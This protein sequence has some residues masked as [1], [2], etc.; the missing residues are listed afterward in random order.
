MTI[1]KVI[2][3]HDHG[4]ENHPIQKRL[5]TTVKRVRMRQNKISRL[6]LKANNYFI[7]MTVLERVF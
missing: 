4:L 7:V 1:S 3:R 2:Y 5:K 6:I